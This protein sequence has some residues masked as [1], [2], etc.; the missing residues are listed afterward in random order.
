MSTRR[1]LNK[2]ARALGAVVEWAD[3]GV[4]V[5]APRFSAW[6]YTGC[7]TIFCSTYNADDGTDSDAYAIECALEGVAAGLYADPDET[8]NLLFESEA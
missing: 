8:D 2:A 7:G 3:D 1:E 5:D 4:N 6:N